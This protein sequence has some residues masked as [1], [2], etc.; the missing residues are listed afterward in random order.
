MYNTLLD[1]CLGRSSRGVPPTINES[2]FIFELST[3]PPELITVTMD[4]DSLFKSGNQD[5]K[6]I[7]KQHIMYSLC[8]VILYHYSRICCSG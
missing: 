7:G 2:E 3:M 1:S 5:N 4:T 6:I 8:K